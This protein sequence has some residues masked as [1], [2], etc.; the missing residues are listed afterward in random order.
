MTGAACTACGHACC[1]AEHPPVG[2]L[3]LPDLSV[4]SPLP[5]Q[6]DSPTLIAS[7]PI[8][9]VATTAEATARLE[10]QWFHTLVFT[11]CCLPML[12]AAGSMST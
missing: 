10:L 1:D 3:T 11:R 5:G 8:S 6:Q 4:L 9:P 12:S 7:G 2:L